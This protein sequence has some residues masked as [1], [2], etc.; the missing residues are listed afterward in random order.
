ME[1]KEIEALAAQAGFEYSAYLD[2][3]RL[4][5]L[6][7]VRDMCKVNSCGK[8]GTNR[9]CPP[10]CGTME[11]CRERVSKYSWGIVLQTVG[12]IEDSLDFEGIMEAADTHTRRFLAF[13]KQIRTAYPDLLPLGTGHCSI[14]RKC[15]GPDEPCLFPDECTSPPEAYGIVV[16]DLCR[17]NGLKY[18]YGPEKIAYTACCLLG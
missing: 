1:F 6:D 16:S 9:G 8:Y 18:Y 5:L 17:D 12:D 7:E 10:Y 4:S 3:S 11:Q 15:V 13:L 2:C 14:C